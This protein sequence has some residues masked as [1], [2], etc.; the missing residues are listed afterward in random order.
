[1]T[2]VTKIIKPFIDVCEYAQSFGNLST[3]KT[4]FK[5]NTLLPIIEE[6]IID[7]IIKYNGNIGLQKRK[8]EFLKIKKCIKEIFIKYDMDIY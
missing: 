7:I 1:M 3:K 6:Q 8:E 4:T 2:D 5:Y